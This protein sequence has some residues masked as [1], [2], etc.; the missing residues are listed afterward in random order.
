[1]NDLIKEIEKAFKKINQEI[2]DIHTKSDEAMIITKQIHIII[3]KKE[4]SIFFNAMLKPEL[5]ALISLTLYRLQKIH[6]LAIL[7][8][9]FVFNDNGEILYGD[10]AYDFIRSSMETKIKKEHENQ[11]TYNSILTSHPGFRC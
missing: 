5:A 7:L 6:S 1:M 2:L 3:S 4:I 11:M 10:D 9:S 8:S